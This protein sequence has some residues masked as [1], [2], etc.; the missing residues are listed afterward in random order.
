MKT[1]L[2]S[3]VETIDDLRKA[4]KKL[5][6]DYHPDR[7]GSTELMQQLNVEYQKLFR[8]LKSGLLDLSEV[9]VGDVVFVNG[10]ECSVT[11]VS[12]FAFIAKSKMNGRTAVF[13]KKTGYAVGNKKFK[14]SLF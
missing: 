4:Y 10:T 11:H 8:L 2:I 13:D 9:R 6:R 3:G 5:A 12:R 7:G 14:A 1:N